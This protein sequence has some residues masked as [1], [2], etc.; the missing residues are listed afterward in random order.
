M[1]GAVPATV[2]CRMVVGPTFGLPEVGSRGVEDAMFC[3][4]PD[5]SSQVWTP[6]SSVLRNTQRP[7]L[8]FKKILA[9]PPSLGVP[10]Q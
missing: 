4:V 1:N 8:M 10:K 5:A 7:K 3:K 2:I 6:M 9:S